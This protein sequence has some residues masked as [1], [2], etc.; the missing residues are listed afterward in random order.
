MAAISSSWYP[1]LVSDHS[2][3]E[4]FSHGAKVKEDLLGGDKGGFLNG[5][6]LDVRT[7][8]LYAQL[9]HLNSFSIIKGS[10]EKGIVH[11]F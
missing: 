5:L 9:L 4:T 8:I 3:M 2:Q 6:N 11:S 10:I 1:H 7:F